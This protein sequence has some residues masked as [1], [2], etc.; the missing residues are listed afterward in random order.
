MELR[1]LLICFASIAMCVA[2]Y[3]YGY[4]FVKLKNYFLGV[5]WLILATS[6]ANFAFYWVTYSQ[7]SWDIMVFLD[8]FSR[9]FGV[10]LVAVL[11]MMAATHKYNPPISTDVWLFAVTL[12]ATAVLLYVEIFEPL[13]PYIYLTTWYLTL[14]YLIYV[15]RKLYLAGETAV[16]VHMTIGLIL[17]TI[18]LTIYDF[19][20]IPGDETNLIFNFYFIAM[21][22]WGYGFSVFYFAYV[23]LLRIADARD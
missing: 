18:V 11:G 20:P 8:A 1:S 12:A 9:M 10:T 4:R 21:L 3:V 5:E 2:L 16:T 13:L 19:F 7:I 22:T 14:I 15:T 6:A 23:A 17:I